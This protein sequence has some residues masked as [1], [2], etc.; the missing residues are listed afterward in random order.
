MKSMVH[1]R[2]DVA[3]LTLLMA[4]RCLSPTIHHERGYDGGS[5]A[6]SG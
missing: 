5:A 4:L 1:A 3:V 2:Q 6:P